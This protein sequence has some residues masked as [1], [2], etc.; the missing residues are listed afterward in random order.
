MPRIL[1]VCLFLGAAGL[2]CSDGAGESCSTACPVC[3]EC[4]L[5]VCVP[6]GNCDAGVDGD[7]AGDTAADADADAPVEAEGGVDADVD[8]PGDV[9]ADTPPDTPP[10]VPVDVPVDGPADVP[11]DVTPDAEIGREDVVP[12]ADGGRICGWWPGGECGTRETCDIRSCFDGASGTC[13]PTPNTCPDL[14]APVC[15]CDGYTY[16]NDCERVAAGAALDHTGECET[17]P[18]DGPMCSSAGRAW[19]WPDGTSICDAACGGCVAECRYVGSYSEGWYAVC[20]DPTFDGGC[21]WPMM[22][23]LIEWA[24]CG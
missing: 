11:V 9:P 6:I 15:G 2:A 13:V 21:G 7:S 12:E 14:W 22:G 17:M 1:F 16:S 5:G 23:D 8:T 19:V 3:Q 10:D 24:D 4:Y 20:I 18:P